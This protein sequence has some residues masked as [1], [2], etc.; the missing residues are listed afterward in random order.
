MV[1]GRLGGLLIPPS[2]QYI[3][4]LLFFFSSFYMSNLM[5]LQKPL[6]ATFEGL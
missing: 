6:G 3:Y 4:I 5:V 1:Y 2:R